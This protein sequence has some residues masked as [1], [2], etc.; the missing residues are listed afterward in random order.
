MQTNT[1]Y[2]VNPDGQFIRRIIK[3]EMLGGLPQIVDK[4]KNTEIVIIPDCF[5]IRYP[6]KKDY[7]NNT[8]RH[9]LSVPVHMGRTKSILH[10]AHRLAYYPIHSRF[11]IRK[12]SSDKNYQVFAKFSDTDVDGEEHRIGCEYPGLWMIYVFKIRNHRI[13]AISN[14]YLVTNIRGRFFAPLLPNIFNNGKICLGEIFIRYQYSMQQTV[15]EVF[16][17]I[18]MSKSTHHLM[19]AEGLENLKFQWIEGEE[20]RIPKWTPTKEFLEEPHKVHSD[21]EC[22]IATELLEKLHVIEQTDNSPKLKSNE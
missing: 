9:E 14:C 13:E 10:V 4:A 2:L 12:I 20:E 7:E 18:Y 22:T 6:S 11:V 19:T 3:E 1:E 8:S 16:N 21:R 17:E 15:Q 5:S